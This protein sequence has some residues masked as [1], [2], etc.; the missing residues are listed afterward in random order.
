[1]LAILNGLISQ[2]SEINIQKHKLSWY[3]ML[4]A[5]DILFLELFKHTSLSICIRVFY[6][7]QTGNSF[8]MYSFSCLSLDSTKVMEALGPFGQYRVI[9]G[10]AAESSSSRCNTG[11]LKDKYHKS[12]QEMA[13]LCLLDTG[14]KMNCERRYNHIIL[15]V[16]Q[17][18]LSRVSFSFY[19]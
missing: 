17:H 15:F 18:I 5:I 6:K 2:I 19:T 9:H 4:K 10:D 14:Q 11:V 3:L 16:L 1:M 7:L 12:T 8:R 13:C